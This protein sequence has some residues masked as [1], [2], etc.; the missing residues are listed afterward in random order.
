[1][2]II[3][4]TDINEDESILDLVLS[5][6][7][8]SN[9]MIL[10]NM[11]DPSIA[12]GLRDWSDAMDLIGGDPDIQMVI[13]NPD[14]F[15][16]MT[17]PFF[18]LLIKNYGQGVAINYQ[19]RWFLSRMGL[20]GRMGCSV[21]KALVIGL[22][23][24]IG[25]EFTSIPFTF[26]DDTFD[27][28]PYSPV[29]HWISNCAACTKDK[30]ACEGGVPCDI[31]SH[32]NVDCIPGKNETQARARMLYDAISS[33]Y[34]LHHDLLYYQL[35]RQA[36]VYDTRKM[37][38]RIEMASVGHRSSIAWKEDVFIGEPSQ[39]HVTSTMIQLSMELRIFMVV[40][41]WD[42]EM[43]VACSE[44]WKKHVYNPGELMDLSKEM[45]MPPLSVDTLMMNDTMG[46]WGT[47]VNAVK[48]PGWTSEKKGLMYLRDMGIKRV[49]VKTVAHV[50]DFKHLVYATGIQILN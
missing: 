5:G 35:M 20:S 31:C 9:A 37:G 19:F 32:R 47:I 48:L 22:T 33:G 29:M 23:C 11:V 2:D 10:C 7:E 40:W 1:M 34:A 42:G 21:E 43:H 38:S 26:F 4:D 6:L 36:D 16:A 44:D 15:T 25:K 8:T 12:V 49:I 14:S 46:Y 3:Q 18:M 45:R 50:I 13:P 17:C 39:C 30:R 24:P 41:L 28:E 27:F